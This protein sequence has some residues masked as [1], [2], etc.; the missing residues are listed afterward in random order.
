MLENLVTIT[1][2]KERRL[3]LTLKGMIEFKK[4]TGKDLLKGFDLSDMSIEDV[5]AL[6]W[7][8]MLHEDKDLAY[9]DVLCLLDV[10]NLTPVINAV[11]QCINQSLPEA[12]V[13]ESPLVG[14]RRHG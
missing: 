14:K 4:Q 3:R 5:S 1:L 6:A 9:D 11:V 12:K 2:D 10:T 7:A 8:C 13:S